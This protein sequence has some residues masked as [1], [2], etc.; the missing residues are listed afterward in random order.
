MANTRYL[1]RDG[2]EITEEEYWRIQNGGSA[3]QEP[4]TK[5]PKPSGKAAKK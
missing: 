4:A 1:D 2:N 5:E 3:G